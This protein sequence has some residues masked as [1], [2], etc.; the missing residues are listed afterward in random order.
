MTHPPRCML[1]SVWWVIWHMKPQALELRES[2]RSM[3][4]ICR[5]RASRVLLVLLGWS[6][7]M[8][9][10][11]CGGFTT[12]QCIKWGGRPHRSSL[13]AH[14][15]QHHLQ[16]HDTGFRSTLPPMLYACWS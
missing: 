5:N 14:C 2:G 3:G 9:E 13:H 4:Q 1:N 7:H 15:L 11:S 12:L 16:T 10:V 8:E 6:Y